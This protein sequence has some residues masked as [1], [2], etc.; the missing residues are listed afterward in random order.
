MSG[1]A[2]VFAGRASLESQVAPTASRSSLLTFTALVLDKTPEAVPYQHGALYPLLIENLIPRILWPGKPTA[3]QSNQ[4]FQ[5][6]YG[7]T[8]KEDLPNVSMACGFEAEGYMNFGWLGTI[9]VGLLVGIAFA[10]Y[11]CAF[12]STNSSLA[13]TA[14][15]LVLLVP[16]FLTIEWQLVTYLGNIVQILFA[17][18]VVFHRGK[19]LAPRRGMSDSPVPSAA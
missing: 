13:A 3:N 10:Y 16:G 1:W 8:A 15:G 12:F 19:A 18:G 14:V 9:I 2:D 11:E 5:V 17:T 6:E 7:V 4:F